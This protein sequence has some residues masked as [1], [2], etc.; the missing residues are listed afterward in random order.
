M[1]TESLSHVLLFK[2][3]PN[4]ISLVPERG[5]GGVKEKDRSER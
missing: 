3:I 4:F 5:G 2:A 1:L